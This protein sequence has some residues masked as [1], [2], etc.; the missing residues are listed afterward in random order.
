MCLPAG[1]NGPCGGK[2]FCEGAVTAEAVFDLINTDLPAGFGMD[3]NTA[4]EAGTRLTYIGAGTVVNWFQCTT[5]YGGCNADGG[6]L[7]YLVADDDNANINDGT[8]HMS[9]IF[10]A[11]D[12]HGIACDVPAVVDS[13]CAGTPAAAPVVAAAPLDRGAS[14]SWGAVAGVPAQ[15]ESTTAGRSQAMPWRSKAAKIADMWGV[16]SLMSPLSSSATR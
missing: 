6:Y 13:G 9:A 5:P 8:P 2:I 4:L 7:N 15:P 16:P 11:F 1:Q 10:A 12:R 3:H 14:L